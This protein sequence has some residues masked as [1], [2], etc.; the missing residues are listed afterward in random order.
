[1]RKGWQGVGGGG[2]HRP[3]APRQAMRD[4]AAGGLLAIM[5]LA[6]AARAAAAGGVEISPHPALY[7]M[8]LASARSGSSVI[9]AQGTMAYEW[10]ETC[11]GWTVQQNY[12]LRMRYADSQDVN[13]TSNFVTWEAKDGLRY[14]FNQKETRNGAVD[15]D[16]RGQARLDGRGKG[17]VAQFVK[18]EAKTLRLPP[19]TL[20][21]SAHTIFLIHE[22]EAGKQFVTRRIFDGSTVDGAAQVS[23]VIGPPAPP[24][25][26]ADRKNP[27]LNHRGWR[28]RL[29]FF[30]SDPDVETPDYEIGMRLLDDGV[31]Q[32]LVIDYGDYAIQA[33]LDDIESRPKPNC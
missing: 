18:P 1:M 25:S 33:T 10:G 6:P 20:F 19:G 27:L 23:A 17:G 22:A 24:E 28:V 11:D 7:K 30:S 29:A 26:A 16:I 15:Q 31:S 8:T 32:D 2:A 14:R 13:L 12:R 3:S 5:A 9:D 21:P 4:V